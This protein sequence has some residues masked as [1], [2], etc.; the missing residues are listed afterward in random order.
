VS[1]DVI[2]GPRTLTGLCA[3]LCMIV[4]LWCDAGLSQYP[5]NTSPRQGMWG[6]VFV[7]LCFFACL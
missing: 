4:V 5:G 6:V 3:P 7:G 1:V 2:F